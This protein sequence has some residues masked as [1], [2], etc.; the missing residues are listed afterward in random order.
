MG[1][2]RN[3]LIFV[4][5][6]SAALLV[7]SFLIG[8]A[9]GFFLTGNP[10][11]EGK[12]IWNFVMSMIDFALTVT[13]AI[14]ASHYFDK[15]NIFQLFKVDLLQMSLGVLIGI[16]TFIL[17]EIILRTASNFLCDLPLINEAFA[18]IVANTKSTADYVLLLI[19]I[20]ILVPFSEEV[21]L[22]G[23]CYR[24]LRQRYGRV[25]SLLVISFVFVLFHPVP[26]WIPH[27]MMVTIVLC[28][29]FEYKKNLMLPITIHSTINVLAILK[30]LA[31]K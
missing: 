30:L 16:V 14:S 26:Q 6:F 21:F 27:L 12:T 17:S 5:T 20:G 9:E 31:L 4:L 3:P 8:I 19:T 23:F 7:I 15:Q 29:S 13:L 18:E 10:N 28:F 1:K 11:L 22:R 25:V 24:V 2:I